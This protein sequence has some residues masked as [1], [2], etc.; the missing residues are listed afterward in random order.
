MEAGQYYSLEEIMNDPFTDDITK[1]IL[2]D[3]F[4]RGDFMHDVFDGQSYSAIMHQM[5]GFETVGKLSSEAID[6]LIAK[7][8]RDITKKEFDTLKK[9][10]IVL[11][12]KKTTTTS[13][14]HYLKLSESYIDRNDVS[15]LV[16][17]EGMTITEVHAELHAIYSQVYSNRLAIQAMRIAK[18]ESDIKKLLVENKGLIKDAHKYFVAKNS[19]KHLHVLLNSMEMDNV[20]QVLDTTASKTTT[21]LPIEFARAVNKDT[22]YVNLEISSQLI[23]NEWKYN[24]VETSKLKDESKVSIQRKL[25]IPAD[26]LHMREILD[27]E[28]TPEEKLQYDSLVNTINDYDQAMKNSADAG[29]YTLKTFLRD[30]NNNIIVGKMYDLILNSLE[31]Q[32]SPDNVK[33]L[34]KTNAAGKPII[35]QNTPVIRKMLE[36]YFFSLYSKAT[37]EK[38]SGTKFIHASSYGHNV[39]VDEN[40]N[41]IREEIIEGNPELYQNNH[42]RPLGVTTEIGED[43]ITRYYV[44]AIVA[45]PFFIDEEDKEFYLEKL[46]KFFGT[47]VPTEDKRSM[48]IVKV[49]DFVN[50]AHGNTIILPQIAHYLAG[51]DFDIDTLYTQMYNTY[52]DFKGNK[53]LYGD[54]SGYRNEDEGRFLEY[55]NHK[56]NDRDLSRLVNIEYS[57]LYENPSTISPATADILDMLGYTQDDLDNFIAVS[58]KD[59]DTIKSELKDSLRESSDEKKML[60]SS[61]D[62][63]KQSIETKKNKGASIR[64]LQNVFQQIN[65]LNSDI[66]RL[67]QEKIEFYES[68]RRASNFFKISTNI[69]SILKVFSE[70]N[71]PTSLEKFNSKLEYKYSVRPIYQNSLLTAS[72][73][74]ISNPLVFKNVYSNQ[75]ASTESFDKVLDT[76]GV[77]YKDVSKNFPY[78]HHSISGL[79]SAK[80][81]GQSDKDNVSKSASI[82]KIIAFLNAV[83]SPGKSNIKSDAVVWKYNVPIYKEG[84]TVPSGYKL[85]E[86]NTYGI[87]DQDY[88]RIIQKIGDSI[89]MF[90]DAGKEPKP[91]L[92]GINDANSTFILSSLGLGLNDNLA[93]NLIKMP[94]YINACNAVM[95]STKALTKGENVIIK[96]LY[97]AVNDEITKLK[98]LEPNAIAIMQA[99]GIV[100]KNSGYTNIAIDK[101]KIILEI[102]PTTFDKEKLLNN[103]LSLKD[104]GIEVSYL[105]TITENK[106][107]NKKVTKVVVSQEKVELSEVQQKII[108]LQMMK[109]QALQSFE[110]SQIGSLLNTLKSFKPDM[111]SFEFAYDNIVKL[112][113]KQLFLEDDV[114]NKIFSENKLWSTQYNIVKD[115]DEQAGILFLEKS[116]YFKSIY[117]LFKTSLKDRSVISTTLTSMLSIYKYRTEYP[118]SRKGMDE[119]HQSLIDMDD[120]NLRDVFTARYWFSHELDTQL[121]EFKEKYPKNKFLSFL[122]VYKTNS[123]ALTSD[124]RKFNESY[125]GLSTKAKVSEELENAISIDAKV[126]T[127]VEPLFMSKLFYHDLA[128]TGL[129]YKLHSYLKYLDAS[130]LKTVS[131]YMNDFTNKLVSD[132]KID[133]G[134]T[135]EEFINVDNKENLYEI[136]TNIFDTISVLGSEQVANKNL[137]ML[138]FGEKGFAN[139]FINKEKIKAE[140]KETEDQ[141]IQKHMQVYLDQ[142]VNGIQFNPG[143]Y[144]AQFNAVQ[145]IDPVTKIAKDV[146]FDFGHKDS[147]VSDELNKQIARQFNINYD[148]QSFKYNFPA[149][150]KLDNNLYVLQ[151]VGDKTDENIMQ[152]NSLAEN[153][154]NN[155]DKGINTFGLQATYKKLNN[156]IFFN[157]TLNPGTLNQEETQTYNNLILTGKRVGTQKTYLDVEYEETSTENTMV[158][159]NKE[160]KKLK[161]Q[162]TFDYNNNKRSDVKANTTFDAI[163]NGERTATTRYEGQKGFDYWKQAEVGDIITWQSADGRTVDVEVTKEFHPLVGSNKTAKQWSKLEGWSIDYFNNNV[164]NKLDKAWQIEYKLID[165]NKLSNTAEVVSQSPNETFITYTPKGKTEQVYVVRGSKVFNKNGKE[166]FKEN[167]VD[168]NKIF[169]NV[170]VKQKRGIVVEYDGAKYIVNTKQQILSGTTGKLMAWDENNGNRIA[171]LKLASDKFAM[172]NPEGL[173]SIDRTTED[174]SS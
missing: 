144:V 59:F 108:L 136:L 100:S 15:T 68:F 156:N 149:F 86:Y 48:V 143:K 44:E 14:T 172:N 63:L 6:I 67:K 90:T 170:A 11:N 127:S 87:L 106:T 139:S 45:K 174:C 82:N 128:R 125:I 167:G 173:P 41:V 99:Q 120:Q 163:L 78:D 10:R 29:F 113:T 89:G 164:K 64:Q 80:V 16:I 166:V 92:L 98:I 19:K 65:E 119:N 131:K 171:I 132:E 150:L 23:S 74:V 117:N 66:S 42:V 159:E 35:N 73:D 96:S 146:T 38:S 1:E 133:I 17:P 56:L 95:N 103:T 30:E 153:F 71:L 157:Q 97:K 53:Q 115:L 145:I 112:K 116:P 152:F 32:N 147:A 69:E 111:K 124:N 9:E 110:L 148:Y 93:F 126:L 60:K 137:P 168:R 104:L 7:H 158:S 57:K 83:T 155:F 162:M 50:E 36:Y 24:Q 62:G 47:R 154:M 37:D 81:L 5:D 12:P 13:R 84:E 39:T 72:M 8:Y 102:I 141:A 107:K 55:I 109:E 70:Y 43:G 20:D 160:I 135:I 114:V 54:Y 2:A 118:G 123:I 40:N 79:I 4:K 105:N 75:K 34:F 76:Q 58:Q 26:V 151:S 27:R 52:I 25:I 21:I 129:Q 18:E 51:S 121:N 138:S 165:K 91:A 122:R 134:K 101:S 94:E 46:N 85:V 31:S 22:E 142:I 49:V 77:D 28:F 3:S 169:A 140:D 33:D 161:G 130:Y 61:I 88:N